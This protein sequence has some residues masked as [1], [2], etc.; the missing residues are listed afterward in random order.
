MIHL[1]FWAYGCWYSLFLISMSPSCKLMSLEHYFF[2]ISLQ[3]HCALGHA[4]IKTLHPRDKIMSKR[5]RMRRW[6]ITATLLPN[7]LPNLLPILVPS[8][9]IN[10]HTLSLCI[11][12]KCIWLFSMPRY[13]LCRFW[14]IAQCTNNC[15][16]IIMLHGSYLCR[17]GSY[18]CREGHPPLF[19]ILKNH[20]PI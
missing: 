10:D 18:L 17:E 16:Q 1:Q 9:T 15:N 13:W 14:F 7:L 3:Y 11:S 2:I 6:N 8:L 12:I 5:Y 20:T 4:E 19:I